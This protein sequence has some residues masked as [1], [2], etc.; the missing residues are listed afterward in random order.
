MW[1]S[2]HVL[3]TFRNA[4]RAAAWAL[5]IVANNCAMFISVSKGSRAIYAKTG[6][7]GQLT[8]LHRM[9]RRGPDWSALGRALRRPGQPTNPT[10]PEASKVLLQ[11]IVPEARRAPPA[12]AGLTEH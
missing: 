8:L 10:E 2:Y 3:N 4:F 1:A 6:S 7:L 5:S 9:R 11:P 12:H